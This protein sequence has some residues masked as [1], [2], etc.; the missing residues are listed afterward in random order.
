MKRWIINILHR[1]KIF[2]SGVERSITQILWLWCT[3][4]CHEYIHTLFAHHRYYHV[5]KI[6]SLNISHV[7]NTFRLKKKSYYCMVLCAHVFCLHST[8]MWKNSRSYFMYVGKSSVHLPSSISENMLIS[9][10]YFASW[11]LDNPYTHTHTRA[12][13]HTKTKPNQ[14]MALSNFNLFK[15]LLHGTV[16]SIPMTFIAMQYI[17]EGKKKNA[18]CWSEWIKNSQPKIHSVW[19]EIQLDTY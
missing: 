3:H 8:Q 4:F 12:R 7:E 16:I 19:L 9:R 5:I 11:L 1:R 15:I 13:T 18:E 14:T 6:H 17:Q 2:F 10:H